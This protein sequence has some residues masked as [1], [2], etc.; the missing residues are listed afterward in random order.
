MINKSFFQDP[1]ISFLF[2]IHG[3]TLTVLIHDSPVITETQRDQIENGLI[4]SIGLACK[5]LIARIDMQI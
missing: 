2:Y 4:R 5:F 1:L 3:V